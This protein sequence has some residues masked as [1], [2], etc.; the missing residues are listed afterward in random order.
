MARSRKRKEAI[1]AALEYAKKY[2]M[3]HTDYNNHP[4]RPDPPIQQ[5][6]TH[7]DPVSTAS[8]PSIQLGLNV[9]FELH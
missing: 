8:V 5:D 7:N 4:D 2:H 1:E 9:Y 3:R 6:T